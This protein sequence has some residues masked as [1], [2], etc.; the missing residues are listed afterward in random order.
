MCFR[1]TDASRYVAGGLRACRVCADGFD[2]C[3]ECGTLLPE[4]V[5]C[6][7]CRPDGRVWN[8]SYKPNPRFFGSGRHRLFLGAELEIIV[9]DDTYAEC[10]DTVCDRVGRL[11]YLKR[12]ASIE[13]RGFELVTHPMDYRFAIEE[14]P[15][16]LLGELSDLGCQSDDRVGLHV[17][18]S[19]AGF[20]SPAHIYRWAK[21]VYRNESHTVA[22]ARRRSDYAG[23]SPA[24][25]ARVKDSAKGDLRR[26]GLDRFQAINPHPRHTLELRVFAGSLDPQ[27]VQAA[28]AFTAASIEYTRG[29]TTADVVRRDGWAWSR[30]TAWVD[31]HPEYAPLSAEME[32]LECA[33]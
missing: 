33:C 15:W 7:G 28:L 5:D 8:Y 11:A 18:A 9:P 31:Y 22:L 30:F 4:G 21:L 27:R 10:V 16:P 19:R 2:A 3:G 1:Y 26:F 20:S 14:F 23:F 13:P 24:A 25:R 12:D 6:D 32:A 17:H 29:L